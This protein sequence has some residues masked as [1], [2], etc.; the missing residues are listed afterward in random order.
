MV[1]NIYFILNSVGSPCGT[2]SQNLLWF[3]LGA[4]DMKGFRIDLPKMCFFIMWIILS[5]RQPVGS[6]EKFTSLLK[7]LN[8]SLAHNK[9]YY[10]K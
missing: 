8:W 5:L 2:Q 10:Q 9:G 4:K 7:N 1:R 3:N 6:R